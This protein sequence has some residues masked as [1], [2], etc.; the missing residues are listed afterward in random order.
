MNATPEPKVSNMCF[1][2]EA[3]FSWRK[4]K[5]A[6]ALTLTN[7]TRG[8]GEAPTSD[9]IISR[10]ANVTC[11]LSGTGLVDSNCVGSVRLGHEPT[12]RAKRD[13]LRIL[14]GHVAADAIV[15]LGR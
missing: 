5:P 7:S 6:S 3:P 2:G 10:A 8:S 4:V 11:R 9:A 1:S 13:G 12:C 14:L 15:R